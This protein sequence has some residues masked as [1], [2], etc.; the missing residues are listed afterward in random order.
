MFDD[1]LMIEQVTNNG[2]TYFTINRAK[3][4]KTWIIQ[5]DSNFKTVRDYCHGYI[6]CLEKFGVKCALRYHKSVKY[7]LNTEEKLGVIDDNDFSDFVLT[8]NS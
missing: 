1:V 2:L 4:N 7:C 5:Y 3:T 8:L 6:D